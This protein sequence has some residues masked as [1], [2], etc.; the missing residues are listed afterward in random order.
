M[1]LKA[2]IPPRMR[3]ALRAIANRIRYLG[4]RIAGRAL[5]PLLGARAPIRGFE[6][7][8]HYVARSKSRYIPIDPASKGA[9]GTFVVILPYGRAAFDY[10]EPL[11]RD[12]MLLADVSPRPWAHAYALSMVILPRRTRIRS[13]IAVVSTWG[14]QNYYHWMIDMLPRFDLLRIANVAPD[15]FIVNTGLPYQTET[16]NM[17]GVD[18]TK[19]IIPTTSTLI[20]A[21]ELIVPSLTGV[22]GTPT[23]RSCEFLRRVFL[24]D[25]RMAPSKIIY[26]S[27]RLAKDRRLTNESELLQ[28]LTKYGVEVVELERISVTE[29]V[30]LFASAKLVIGPHGA[31]FTNI[32][33]CQKGSSVIEFMPEFYFVDYFEILA[34][35]RALNYTRLPARKVTASFDHV[36]GIADVEEAIERTLW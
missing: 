35:L 6:E 31:G 34:N 30:N 19:I 33:F 11:T 23:L 28:R 8:A 10:G 32:V 4:L 14:Y 22:F 36:V 18:P 26:I 29:Q 27:R 5:F 21:D 24:R 2:L 12:H 20:E 7:T 17:L 1:G 15:F 3:P 9:P 13:N 16:L 25:C